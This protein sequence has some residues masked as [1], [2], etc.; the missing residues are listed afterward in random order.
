MF[1]LFF[2]IFGFFYFIHFLF[3]HAKHTPT[4][5]AFALS[6]ITDGLQQHGEGCVGRLAQVPIMCDTSKLNCVTT[7]LEFLVVRV[8][9]CLLRARDFSPDLCGR[10]CYQSTEV[11]AN[12]A[13]FFCVRLLL[14]RGATTPSSQKP[15]FQKR[16]CRRRSRAARSRWTRSRATWQT[17]RFLKHMKVMRFVTQ[18]RKFPKNVARR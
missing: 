10:C 11:L 4:V 12:G 16:G 17:R 8:F 2:S 5:A 13:V 14:K 1:F 3:F 6:P 15:P 9:L 7:R 18:E